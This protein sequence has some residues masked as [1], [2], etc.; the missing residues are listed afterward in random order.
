MAIIKKK[1]SE[2]LSSVR[3]EL[4]RMVDEMEEWPRRFFPWAG[5]WPVWPRR[6]MLARA[7]RFP[8][9]DV[10]D[11]KDKIIVK[12]EVPGVEKEDIEVSI[13]ED[14]LTIKGET[15]KEKEVKEED[16]YCCERSYGS[17]SRS[18]GLPVKVQTDKIKANLKDGVLE[19]ELPK[20]EAEKPKEIKVEVK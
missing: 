17:F 9:V 19:V 5:T 1:P 18:V 15:K 6:H 3:D 20:V 2:E 11:K 4:E 12:A 13:T 7:M 16:Y 14:S 8:S 10:I